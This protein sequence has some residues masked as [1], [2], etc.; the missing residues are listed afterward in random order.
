MQ[1]MGSDQNQLK[2][3]KQRNADAERDVARINQRRQLERD[4]SDWL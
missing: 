4:V 2:T 1:K 3:L